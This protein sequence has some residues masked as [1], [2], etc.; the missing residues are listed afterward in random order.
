MT[1]GIILITKYTYIAMICLVFDS[2]HVILMVSYT[3][4]PIRQCWVQS[5]MCQKHS[6]I[7]QPSLLDTP[8]FMS[9][10]AKNVTE[11]GVLAEVKQEI[12]QSCAMHHIVCVTK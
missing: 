7:V 4:I 10:L 12:Y 3:C 5:I 1:C 8:S 6:G 9:S 2:G 11:S